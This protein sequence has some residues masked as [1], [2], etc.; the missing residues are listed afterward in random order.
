MT[1]IQQDLFKIIKLKLV[2]KDPLGIALADILHISPDAVYRRYRGETILTIDEVQRLC[3][4]FDISIDLLMQNTNGKAV[5]NY[6][7]LNSYDFRLE[8]YLEG[9]LNSLR[10]L[11]SLS[12]PHFIMSVS[13]NHIFQLI[14]FPQLARFRLF[15]WAK[16]H[17]LVPEYQNVKYFHEKT[18]EKAF[19]L[20]EEI[21]ELYTSIPS[22]EIFDPE[23]MRG[24]LRQIL[25][26]YKAHLFE[27]PSDALFLCDRM[28]LLSKHLNNQAE[29]GKKFIFGKEIPAE[30]NKFQMYLNETINT[31]STIYY[32]SKE[33][34]GIFLTHN[35]MNYLQTVD[36]KYVAD[37]KQIIDKQL[38][39]SSLISEVNE[40]ERNN[41]FYE[42]DKT[43]LSFRKKIEA[44]IE[45]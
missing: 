18:S 36:E 40:K 37:S 17:L 32:S 19:A 41:Y 12:N 6:N 30:G 3:K 21:L 42:F 10:H 20:G 35:I 24:F 13:N 38:A 33:S 14:N 39:N 2:G 29:I 22:I 9:I 28:L 26:Y 25:Y 34:N 1:T 16:T 27:D 15:F 4:H 44:D 7:P 45:F 23:L 8:S 43:I 31:D 5:F 11:K